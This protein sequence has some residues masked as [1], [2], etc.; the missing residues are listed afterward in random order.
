MKTTMT[1]VRVFAGRVVPA[2]GALAVACGATHAETSPTG[3]PSGN[4]SAG[5][6]GG[7][8][9]NVG[10]GGTRTGGTAAGG[11]GRSSAGAGG[12]RT[13][14]AGATGGELCEIALPTFVNNGY[15]V[16]APNDTNAVAGLCGPEFG[17]ELGNAEVCGA[18]RLYAYGHDGRIGCAYDVATGE[19]VGGFLWGL[20]VAGMTCGSYFAGPA[21][22]SSCPV[23]TTPYCR[24]AGDAA[25]SSGMAG[26]RSDG[27][28]AG[29]P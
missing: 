28:A 12:T 7:T 16:C 25:G 6:G 15:R 5:A 18:F 14:S 27:G 24:S 21:A 1:E 8:P 11:A 20:P 10:A 3:G 2:L 17:G 19:L 26:P 4:A 23:P 9:I 13:G 22:V 29:G